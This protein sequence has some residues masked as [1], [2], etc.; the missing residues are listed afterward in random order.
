M[1]TP[2]GRVIDLPPGRCW[3]VTKPRMDEL[4]RDNRVWFGEDGGNVPR[5]KVFITEAKEGLTP[6]TL[7]TAEE[8]GTNDSAKKD[9]FRLFDGIE[10]FDTPKPVGLVRRM[11]EIATEQSDTV[12]DFFAGSG[13]S[14]Q[15]VIEMN[16]TDG[17]N[18]K[19]VLV[20]LPELT[21]IDSLPTIASVTPQRDPKEPIDGGQSWT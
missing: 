20:Q 6:H 4:I 13:V 7:W 10:A 12:L 15:A 16:Q 1:T 14:G 17:G 19:L 9:L 3:A 18:R 21:G 8:V 11:L 2:N 5:R